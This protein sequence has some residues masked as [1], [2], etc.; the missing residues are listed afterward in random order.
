LSVSGHAQNVTDD[1]TF[2]GD[3]ATAAS[4]CTFG[5]IPCRVVTTNDVIRGSQNN[6]PEPAAAAA[7]LPSLPQ[8]T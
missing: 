2:S 4:D 8:A 7:R 1:V 3:L 6:R 5:S